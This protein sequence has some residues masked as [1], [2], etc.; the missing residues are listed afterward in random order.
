MFCSRLTGLPPLTVAEG[1][2]L[3]TVMHGVSVQVNGRVAPIL[4]IKQFGWNPKQINFQVPAMPDML[5]NTA[6]VSVTQNNQVVAVYF[7]APWAGYSAD[8]F[9]D[10]ENFAMILRKSDRRFLESG[11]SGTAR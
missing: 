7:E 6:Y 10:R 1:Y 5:R 8:F 11:G 4:A 3:P 9:V 2:P